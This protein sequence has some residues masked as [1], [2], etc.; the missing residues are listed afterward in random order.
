M[1]RGERVTL[2]AATRADLPALL[3]FHND[4]AFHQL[5]SDD[6]WE[7]QSPERLA[8]WFDRRIEDGQRDG[9]AFAIEAEGRYIGHCRLHTFN[10]VAR[11]CEIGIGIGDPADR[12]RGLGREALAL[13]LAYAFDQWN[14]HKVALTTDA[15]NT[16]A[17]RAYLACGFVEE[18]R[19][20]QHQWCGGRYIDIVEMGLLRAEWQAS[21]PGAPKEIEASS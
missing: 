19:R 14:L 12:G 7:P 5:I 1:L 20:R 16:A 15:D 9:P 17:I 11:I 2:R 13:L 18:G 6:P 8:A 4:V 10:A 21:V 3:A